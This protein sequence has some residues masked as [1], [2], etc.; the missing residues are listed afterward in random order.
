MEVKVVHRFARI[1]P[2]KVRPLAYFVKGK[3]LEEVLSKLPFIRKKA[4]SLIVNLAKQAKT[5][6]EERGANE[7]LYVKNFFVDDGP[8]YK[9]RRIES[10][11]RV[12]LYKHRLSHITMIVSDEVSLESAAKKE[13]KSSNKK[14]L[15]QEKTKKGSVLKTKKVKSNSET[16]KEKE[17][18]E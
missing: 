2:R 12:S 4:A 15:T 5:L 6:A 11:G 10:R 8:A 17:Q 7:K 1:S 13:S 18:K 14:A 9:R 3:L 16:L